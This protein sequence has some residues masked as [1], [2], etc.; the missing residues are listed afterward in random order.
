[1]NPLSKFLLDR[2]KRSLL[3]SAGLLLFSFGFYL[4]L[5]ANIGLSP[6]TALNQGLS[7]HLPITFGQA[8]ILVSVVII[9]SDLLMKES[10]GLGTLLDAFLVGW[11][12]DL[13]IA[14][15]PVPYQTQFLP[16]LGVLFVGMVI[17]CVGQW[18]YMLA[19]LSCGPR[20]AF[21]VALG[22]RL[23]RLS[24]G[25]VNIL[26]NLMV[27]VIAFFLG[28]Q[29]GLGTLIALLGTGMVMDLVFKIV[30]FEPRN[31]EHESLLGTI[32]ALRRAMKDSSARAA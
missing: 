2:A 18:I 8:S 5:A 4:Q 23:S 25:W 31:V 27:A 1:V 29:I 20:D 22:K 13:F 24:I 32:A 16:G 30:K 14:L 3:A 11:G 12:S 19:G 17:T 7:N 9:A 26:L 15:E 28:G 6:W 21:L 10:I